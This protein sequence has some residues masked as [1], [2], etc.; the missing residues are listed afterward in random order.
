[1]FIKDHGSGITR[2]ELLT[3]KNFGLWFVN[4]RAELRL[5]KLW[6]YTQEVYKMEETGIDGE[7]SVK[8]QKKIKA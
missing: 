6:K 1:M 8:I 4:I 7:P 2:I 5:K 3:E